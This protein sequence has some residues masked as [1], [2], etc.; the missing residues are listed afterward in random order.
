[1]QTALPW[2]A[3]P[4]VQEYKTSADIALGVI[5]TCKLPHHGWPY[6]EYKTP[7]DIALGV[8]ETCKLPHHGW[9]YLE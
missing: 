2:V 9:P 1:M 4:G 5:E 6:L 7:A 8:I 3:L